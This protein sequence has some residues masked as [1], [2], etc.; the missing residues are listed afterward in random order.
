MNL[1]QELFDHLAEEHD[2]ILL[3]SEMQEIIN[4]IE[5]HQAANKEVG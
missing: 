1:Y 5:K 2:L 4:I 3:Q